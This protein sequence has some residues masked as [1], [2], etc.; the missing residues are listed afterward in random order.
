[1]LGICVLRKRWFVYCSSEVYIY[2]VWNIDYWF[3]PYVFLFNMGIYSLYCTYLT[4]QY[5]YH[6][7]LK[8]K[9]NKS[10]DLIEGK[11]AFYGDTGSQ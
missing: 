5:P 7:V 4:Y 9:D 11:I 10:G 6:S 2:K 1:M 3:L 8:K